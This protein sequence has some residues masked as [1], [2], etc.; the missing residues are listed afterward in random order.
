[1]ADVA[2]DRA[3]DLSLPR[4]ARRWGVLADSD[5]GETGDSLVAAR[6]AV[7]PPVG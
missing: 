1:V 4:L 3:A 2:L 7:S 6:G 5:V